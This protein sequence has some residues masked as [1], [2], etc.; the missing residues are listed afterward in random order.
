M[1]VYLLAR[2]SWAAALRRRLRG[3]VRGASRR[4]RGRV[5]EFHSLT[6]VAPILIWLVYFLERGSY[7]AFALILAAALL[8]REDV[9][10][11]VSFVALYAI[12]RGGNDRSASAG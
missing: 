10:L 1:P 2:E 3:D 12:L 11:L 7:R 4:A 5:Y 6:L 8:C 9:A